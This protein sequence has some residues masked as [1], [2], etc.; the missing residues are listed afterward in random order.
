VAGKIDP[1]ALRRMWIAG[2]SSNEIAAAFGVQYPAVNRAAKALG[3]PPR[4][5]GGYGKRQGH[6][7]AEAVSQSREQ[8]Q[9]SDAESLEAAFLARGS[10]YAGRAEIAEIFGMPVHRVEQIWH[11]LRSSRAGANA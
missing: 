8:A 10:T 7:Q 9:A 3:L 4:Q 1:V 6:T 2:V 11:R 5:R